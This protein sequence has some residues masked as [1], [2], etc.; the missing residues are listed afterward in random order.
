MR[1]AQLLEAAFPGRLR[2]VYLAGSYA[3]G[4]AGAKPILTTIA[5]LDTLM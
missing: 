5:V 1:V 3:A 2:A 4:T